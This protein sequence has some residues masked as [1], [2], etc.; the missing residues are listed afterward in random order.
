MSMKSLPSA[1]LRIAEHVKQALDTNAPVVALESTVISHGL[2]YPTNFET[3]LACEEII[4]QNGA[5]PATIGIVAGLA[6]IGLTGEE[7]EAFAKTQPDWGKYIRKVGLNNLAATLVKRGW[8]ATTVATSLRLAHA[9]GIRVFST[10]GIGGVHRGASESFDVSGDLTALGSTPV[11]CVCSGAKVI[12]DLAKTAE[13]LETLGV[14]V[15]GYRTTELPAFYA[16][17]SGVTLELSVEEP[18]EAAD[19]ALSHW[20]MGAAT[21]VLVC[22]RVPAEFEM[23]FEE[24]DSFSDQAIAKAARAGIRGKDLTPFLLSELGR[25]TAEK[26]LAANRALLINN[27]RVAAAIAS[28]LMLRG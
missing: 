21:G 9:A 26:S 11:I 25:L 4:R 2:P 20:G 18:R 27:A 24:I 22:V 8:G 15:I 23:G 6:T 14:P 10:G 13:Y 7:I 3:A 17:S 5:T 12:L 1:Q 19:I 28:S 16:S